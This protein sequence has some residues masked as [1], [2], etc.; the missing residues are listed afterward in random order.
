MLTALT[1]A[2][3][4]DDATARP[5]DEVVIEG[6][7]AAGLGINPHD[8]TQG[9][10]LALVRKLL[11]A[12]PPVRSVYGWG[13]AVHLSRRTIGRYLAWAGFP[14]PTEWAQLACL[15]R[16]Q[17]TLQRYGKVNRAAYAAGYPDP[18]TYSNQMHRVIGCRP[19]QVR[20]LS[21][22]Q[23]MSAWIERMRPSFRAPLPKHGRCPFC[24]RMM[25]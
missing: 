16:A 9:R 25:D 7:L 11:T 22:D 5:F 4:V 3:Y 14:K 23:L 2:T 13:R 8:Q 10:A 20:M 6:L 24:Q 17:R 18:F 1:Q 12:E 19:K 21:P 15:L